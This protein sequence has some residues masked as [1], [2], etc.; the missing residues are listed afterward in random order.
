MTPTSA[1]PIVRKRYYTRL[2]DL[3]RYSPIRVGWLN[4]LIRS[5]FRRRAMGAVLRMRKRP[6]PQDLVDGWLS[7]HRLFFCFAVPRAG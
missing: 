2:M 1:K 6:L 7:E 4:P 5:L 3:Y